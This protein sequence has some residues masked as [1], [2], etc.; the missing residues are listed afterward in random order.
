[1]TWGSIVV[2]GIILV[3]EIPQKTINRIFQKRTS[4]IKK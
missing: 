4:G 1:M 3:F 2:L